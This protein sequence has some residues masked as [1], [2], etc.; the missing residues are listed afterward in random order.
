MGGGNSTACD[1]HCDCPSWEPFCYDDGWSPYCT[2]CDWC[3]YCSEGVDGTCGSCDSNYYPVWGSYACSSTCGSD[4]SSEENVVS[5]CSS[6]WDCP[7]S[8]PFCYDPYR[9]GGAWGNIGECRSCE[10]CETCNDGFNWTC[11]SCN[12][13]VY[14]RYESGTCYSESHCG[15]DAWDLLVGHLIGM[16]IGGVLFISLCCC[17]CWG[18]YKWSQ[19]NNEAKARREIP[20]A[21]VS[22]PY[23]LAAAPPAQG[24]YGVAAVPMVQMGS[25]GN[26]NV[27]QVQ[28]TGNQ[29]RQWMRDNVRL[30]EYAEILIGNGYDSLDNVQRLS[31]A[32]LAA[33]GI[34]K[35]GHQKAIM[36]EIERLR[37]Q[38]PGAVGQQQGLLM[39]PQ[40][41]PQ[42]PD[43]AAYQY[44]SGN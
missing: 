27:Q 26:V 31:V 29:V 5:G 37:A 13:E 8:H 1:S 44:S 22:Q 11:G 41:A 34:A 21:A 12:P 7:C 20:K 10:A 35:M 25:E 23:G 16:A 9:T 32:D 6:H 40:P 24:Q 19:Q 17:C 4:S 33:M 42:V 2:S 36:A 15:T 14:P 3:D 38:T 39:Y 30:P 28:Q 43:M 18:I